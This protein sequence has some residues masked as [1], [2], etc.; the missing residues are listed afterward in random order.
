MKKITP[1]LLAFAGT[2]VVLTIVFR[3]FLSMGIE[4][5]E[6]NTI[7]IAA[8]T[9]GLAMFAAG[10]YFG[11]KDGSYLPILDIG[12]RFHVTTFLVHNIISEAWFLLDFN[13]AV[14][15]VRVVHLTAAYWAI[16]LLVHF[17]LYR[18][19]KRKSIDGLDKS[20]IFE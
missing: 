4:N 20:E 19:A 3:Y 6:N 11:R 12:F 14:E 10:W 18:I 7:A 17:I 1:W 8:V 2:A 16:G 5:R 13:A 9:Y 15:K